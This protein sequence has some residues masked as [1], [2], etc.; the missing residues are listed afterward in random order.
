[1]DV[2]GNRIDDAGA[3]LL[4]QAVLHELQSTSW[5]SMLA[6]RLAFEEDGL[7]RSMCQRCSSGG[8]PFFF[9]LHSGMAQN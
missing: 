3:V 1:M 6:R 4:S 2:G 5:L 8:L 7:S 9:E